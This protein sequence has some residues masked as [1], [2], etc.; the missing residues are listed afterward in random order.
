MRGG[1]SLSDARI[2]LQFDQLLATNRIEV[3]HVIR[4]VL[5]LQ[6]VEHQPELL[7]IVLRLLQQGARKGDLVF[8]ELLGSEAGHHAAQVPFQRL[9]GDMT[10]V[11]L[12]FANQAFD[13]VVDPGLIAGDLDI[14]HT[15][16]I[17]RDTTFG[18]GVLDPQLNDHVAEVEAHHLFK[19]GDAQSTP[20]P[21][22]AIPHLA[23]ITSGAA[24]AG[25]DQHFTGLT[26]EIELTQQHYESPK[27]RSAGQ[28]KGDK[29]QLTPVEDRV[30]SRSTPRMSLTCSKNWRTTL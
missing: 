16:H 5:N 4:D 10:N 24:K 27:P 1:L 20:S 22:R 28:S 7:Q 8:I 23:P 14:G 29:H 12:A 9:L 21:Y 30:P 18:V 2:P 19:N 6:R 13:R 15:R 17:E 25:K 3:A 11:V 26:D